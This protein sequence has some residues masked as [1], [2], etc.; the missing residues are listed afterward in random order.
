LSD[1]SPGQLT[2]R[3]AVGSDLDAVVNILWSVAGE[4]RWVGTELP[5]DRRDRRRLYDRMMQSPAATVLVAVI[6]GHVVG[7]AALQVAGYGVADL[8]MAILD[9]YRGRGIGTALLE[10]AIEWARGTGAHKMSLEVWP[11]NEA[12]IALYQ[13][14]GFVEEGRKVRHYRR[15]NG[16]I[17]DAILMGRPLP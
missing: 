3:T 14:V 16:E 4:G 10:A 8:G 17:W 5:F 15:A 1:V 11:H 9:G 7:Q 12:A 13:K 6:D 2:V